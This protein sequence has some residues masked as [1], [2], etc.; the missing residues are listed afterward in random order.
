[1]VS[2]KKEKEE[3]VSI[4]VPVY[5]CEQYVGECIKSI[6]CQ[7]YSKIEVII[8]DDGSTDDSM[9][10]CRE[11]EKADLRIK[12]FTQKNKGVSSARNIGI[13]MA[14]GKYLSFVDADDYVEEDFIKCLIDIMP[15]CGIGICGYKR[16][17][18]DELK[19]EYIVSEEMDVAALYR[20]IFAKND[21][22]SGCWN[23]LF[24]RQVIVNNNLYFDRR[25]A[26]G[27]DMLFL[28]VYLKYVHD[29][30]GYFPKATYIYR[31][32]KKS[33][34]QSTYFN[35]VFDDKKASCLD[36][37][38]KMSMLYDNPRLYIKKCFAYRTVR[39]SLWLLF[40]MIT[41][42]EY[43]DKYADKI[44]QN[45]R[46]NIKEYFEYHEGS[47]L[48]HIMAGLSYISP[49]GVFYIGRKVQKIF[50]NKVKKYLN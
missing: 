50:P 36:A 30:F 46:E 18:E 49:K 11:Y 31:K 28:A 17:E 16:R 43:I 37:V 34:L 45:I 42:N 2:G 40:Q 32:N 41:S 12:V 39:S 27:E 26:V 38:E 35:Q 22:L 47:H 8:V 48:E 44:K 33:T 19:Y 14:T 24:L 7:T 20:Y 15:E 6:L 25:L 3:L 23:K 10:I 13:Q 21:I 1:M 29:N 4:I 9:K 5:N